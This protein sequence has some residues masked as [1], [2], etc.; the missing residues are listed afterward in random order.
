MGVVKKI[1]GASAAGVTCTSL[2]LAYDIQRHR[3][4]PDQTFSQAARH[5]MVVRS[6]SLMGGIYRRRLERATQD[7]KAAQ[8]EFLLGVLEANI[9]TQYS[10][11]M[12]LDKVKTVKDFLTIHPLTRY[13]DYS[14]YVHR[15]LSGEKN[16]LMA[17]DPSV[18]AV[19]SGTSGNSNIVPMAS[20]QTKLFFL[21]GISVLYKCMVDAFPQT[22]L[23]SKDFKI[24]FTPNWRYTP[25]GIPI[26]PNSASPDRSRDLL[27]LYTT[28]E[29]AYE[30]KSEPEAIYLYLLFAVKDKHVGM[31][32]ANFASLIFQAMS[33]LESKL[34]QL[35]E[36]VELGRINPDLNIDAGI[37]QKLDS[38]LSPDPARAKELRQA[39]QGGRVGLASRVWPGLS[40]LMAADTGT[41]DLYAEKLRN[42]YCKGVPLY[43]P[44]YAASEGL[45]GVNIW[46]K[47][48]PSRYLLHPRSQFYEFIPDYLMDED[49][50]R[51]RMMHQVKEGHTYELVI[52]N[53]SCLYRYRFGDVVKVV[54]FH[55]QC[56]I[57]EFKYRKGQFLNV[58]GE[59][60]SEAQFYEILKGTITKIWAD[61][62]LADYCCLESVVLEGMDV[63][64]DMKTS[65]P[66]YHVFVEL[67]TDDGMRDVRTVS[68]AQRKMLDDALMVHS[69][70]YSSFRHKGSIAPIQVHVVPRGSFYD[71][72]R[73][74]L[75]RADAASNQYKVPRVLRKQEAV[76]FMLERRLKQ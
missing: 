46:P 36:D 44:I 58:R 19:T 47:E 67:E 9:G 53:P 48:L 29:V 35:A 20:R 3:V 33:A 6:L 72:R 70:P 4:Y 60:I 63:P 17:E 27:H 71:L 73:F 16:V 62:R 24:F 49:Q 34:P 69:Y 68:K 14:R 41:F 64:E 50:P 11:D 37:R 51:T 74:I 13:P 65:Q 76:Q 5:Y 42:S 75:G 66:C 12:G 10:V 52:T 8:R 31:V 61:T 38:I 30:V 7:V 56:P 1:L 23:L 55:N 15:M 21:E 25:D 57:I 59:K 26:G 18:F 43:S 28:P 32:E 40:M 45:L 39:M 2:L 22:K 54:G